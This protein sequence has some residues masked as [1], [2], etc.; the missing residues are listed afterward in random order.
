VTEIHESVA[1]FLDSIASGIDDLFAQREPAHSPVTWTPRPA[2]ST[3]SNFLWWSCELSVD[4]ACRFFAG[5]PQETWDEL[6]NS[7][8]SPDDPF[9]VV[10]RLLQRAAEARF[11]L[12]VVCASNGASDAPPEDWTYVIATLGETIPPMEFA[13]SPELTAALGGAP[14][15]SGEA[16]AGMEDQFTEPHLNNSALPD[17]NSVD[18][19]MQVEIPVSVSLGQRQ[20]RM[21]ELLGLTKGSIVELN[22]DLGD[23]VEIWANNCVIAKGEVVAV[24]GNYG[25]RILRMVA[26][27]RAKVTTEPLLAA[28]DGGAE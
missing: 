3:R 11:G 6:E 18:M 7:A 1:A 28:R 21:K 4:P 13:L 22:Q 5:A 14:E 20:I 24:D 19:L 23:E 16:A 26:N 10:E 15:L 8:E 25:V 27:S 9:A 17:P 12:E 2:D